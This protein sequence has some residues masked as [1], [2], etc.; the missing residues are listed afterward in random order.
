MATNKLVALKLSKLPVGKHFDGGGLYLE[1][2]PSGSRYWRMKYRLHGKERRAA[3]GV[4]PEVSLGEARDKR[5][6]ARKQ[7]EDLVDPLTARRQAE[8]DAAIKAKGSF[9]KVFED[10]MAVYGIR[11]TERHRL[12]VRRQFD[13]DI[14][15]DLGRR[16]AHAITAPE[17]LGVVRKISDR[18]SRDIALRALQRVGMVF[19]HAMATGMVT[20]H[21]A[22]GLAKAMPRPE[23]TNFAALERDRVKPFLAGLAE[24]SGKPET[25]SA[26]HLLLLMFVRPS[27]LREARWSEFRL[28][29]GIWEIPKERMKG[30][31]PHIVP[32]SKPAVALLRELHTLTGFGQVLFPHRTRRDEPMASSTLLC[33]L[34]RFGFGDIT[35]H[36]FRALA[37]TQLNEH[38]F[39]PDVIEAQLA[40]LE[41]NQTRRAYNKALYLPERKVMMDEWAAMIDRWSTGRKATVFPMKRR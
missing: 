11:W 12:N 39:R 7:V 33:A 8:I 15:P 5:E 4:F 9:A 1:V 37:S 18:G 2:M 40:H 3:F 35:A 10:F 23:R 25:R 24:Y 26:L 30:R 21:P 22:R 41:A 34:K 29:E 28:A 27:E 16:P 14:L 19:D 20:A 32:L 13:N 6:A 38:G 17:V 36:G 31:R